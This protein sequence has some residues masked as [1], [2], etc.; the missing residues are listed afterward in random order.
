[1]H[2]KSY[3]GWSGALIDASGATRDPVKGHQVSS[4]ILIDV[5]EAP[6]N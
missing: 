3:V 4:Q 6:C 2:W 1:M 5:S